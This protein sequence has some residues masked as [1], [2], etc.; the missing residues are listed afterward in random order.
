[1]IL[2]KQLV[3]S[4]EQA[5]TASAYS[6]NLIDL[7]AA[8]LELGIGTPLYIEVWMDTVFSGSTATLTVELRDG[9][10]TSPTD[11]V[12]EILPAISQTAMIA[13]GIGLLAKVLLPEGMDLSRYI[14]LYYAVSASLAGGKLNAFI[15]IG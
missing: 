15:T 1:M 6:T 8:D 12:M 13:K 4:K 3:F 2:D 7:G 10:T 11:K 14:R 9:T 5:V